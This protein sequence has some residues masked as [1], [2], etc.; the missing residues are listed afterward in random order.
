MDDTAAW[1]NPFISREMYEEFLIPCHDRWAKMGRDRGLKMT[2]HNCG[3]CEGILDLLVDIGH[4]F[5]GSR[6]DL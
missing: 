1:A 3:K 5:V 2:M 4:Q 6:A